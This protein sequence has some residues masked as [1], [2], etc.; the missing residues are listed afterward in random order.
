MTSLME[1]GGFEVVPN[2]LDVEALKSPGAAT[3]RAIHYWAK[4]VQNACRLGRVRPVPSDRPADA[5]LLPAHFLLLDSSFLF[6]RPRRLWAA[7]GCHLK[8]VKERGRQA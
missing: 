4:L 7:L 8:M 1:D 2:V 3:Q 5:C 6:S